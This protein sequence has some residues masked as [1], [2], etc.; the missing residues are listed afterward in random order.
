M[1]KLFVRLFFVPVVTTLFCLSFA[2]CSCATENTGKIIV[3]VLSFGGRITSGDGKVLIKTTIEGD[4]SAIHGDIARNAFVGTLSDISS[5]IAIIKR[6]RVDETVAELGIV[7][8]VNV[9]VSEAAEAGK[10]VGAKYMIMGH[11]TI[12]HGTGSGSKKGDK[13]LAA[14]AIL[15][16][17]LI[18]VDN[19]EVIFSQTAD[20]YSESPG[21]ADLEAAAL[22]GTS[23]AYSVNEDIGGEYSHVKNVIDKKN[24]EI[25]TPS[26]NE[27]TLKS[28]YLIYADGKSL[29]NDDGVLMGWER[30]PIAVIKIKRVNRGYSVGEIAAQGGDVNMIREGD[31]ASIISGRESATLAKEKKFVKERPLEMSGLDGGLGVVRTRGVSTQGETE[32]RP[33][34]AIVVPDDGRVRVGVMNLALDSDETTPR[35]ADLFSEFVANNLTNSKSIVAFDQ[36]TLLEMLDPNIRSQYEGELGKE[37]AIELGQMT[38]LRYVVLGSF[39]STNKEKSEGIIILPIPILIGKGQESVNPNLMKVTAK[40]NAV[41]V[42]TGESIVEVSAVDSV[43]AENYENSDSRTLAAGDY[44]VTFSQSSRVTT[45]SR[46]LFNDAIWKPAFVT[47]YAIRTALADE[48]AH[49]LGK[50]DDRW[51]IDIGSMQGVRENALFL[52]YADGFGSSNVPNDKIILAVL[53]V[54]ETEDNFSRCVVVAP[55][56]ESTLVKGDKIEPIEPSVSKKLKYPGSRPNIPK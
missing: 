22:A 13:D 53:K 27:P 38:G 3:G 28:L 23:L 19:G 36:K 37:K 51:V 44:N 20:G 17:K 30:I 12:K 50:Q 10:R 29:L 9:T 6:D 54:I 26:L 46:S 55:S 43:Y 15:D 45:D 40:L 5:T 1:V 16:M 25:I 52:A 56:K 31:K 2:K 48:F 11:V 42:V 14:S 49:V 18:D 33:L 39:A 7:S 21:G 8:P 24:V 35:Q 47:S 34:S 32:N 4:N 41:D